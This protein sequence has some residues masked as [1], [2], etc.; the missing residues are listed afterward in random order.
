MKT[1]F[2]VEINKP[3]SLNG[4][5]FSMIANHNGGKA[6]I[7]IDLIRAFVLSKNAMYPTLFNGCKASFV[8][9]NKLCISEDGGE[10]F[11]L[12]ITQKEVHELEAVNDLGGFSINE[13]G[14]VNHIT[15][16]RPF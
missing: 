2:S 15:N 1:K 8:N 9:E 6:D 7:D 10:T 16:E 5:V 4:E 13:D 12:I 3:G 14:I 11:T